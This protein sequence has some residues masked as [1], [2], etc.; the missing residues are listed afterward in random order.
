MTG[1]TKPGD[2]LADQARD[3]FEKNRKER[4]L[5]ILRLEFRAQMRSDPDEEEDTGVIHQRA[6]EAQRRQESEPPSGKVRVATA[7]LKLLPEGWGR[8]I[9]VLAGIAALTF[10]AARGFKLF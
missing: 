8:V 3:E 9:V 1:D 6:L 2:A 5:A 10:L 7:V 4:E